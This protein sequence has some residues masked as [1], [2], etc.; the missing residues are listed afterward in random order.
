MPTDTICLPET[1]QGGTLTGN[2]LETRGEATDLDLMLSE[3]IMHG[4]AW[5]FSVVA[6]LTGNRWSV[7]DDL[8]KEPA[9]GQSSSDSCQQ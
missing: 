1:N 6:S 2:G 3:G 8:I 9:L 7:S 4:L 5:P